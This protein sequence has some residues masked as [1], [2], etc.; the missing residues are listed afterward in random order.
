[1]TRA[2]TRDA[3]VQDILTYNREREDALLCEAAC[4]SSDAVRLNPEREKT[5]D[6]ANV[7]SAY[8]HDADKILHSLAYTRYIDKT[9]VFYLFDN[10]HITHRVLHVQFVSKIAR[11]IARCLQLN[12]DLV[13]AISLGHDIGHV[14][15]GHDGERFLNEICLSS[16]IGGFCHN[17]QSVRWLLELENGGDGI[18]LCLQTIDGILTHNGEMLERRLEPQREKTWETV[19]DEYRQ[20]MM[21]SAFSKTVRPMT[22]EGCVM[23]VADIIGYVGRDLEDAI[24]LGVISRND[25]PRG[26]VAVLGDTNAA[27]INTLA[28]DCI[29]NSVGRDAVG[30]SGSVFD[31]LAELLA[32]NLERIY[33]NAQVREEDEKLRRLFQVVYQSCLKELRA[34]DPQSAVVVFFNKVSSRNRENMAIPPAR[35]VVDFI[36]GMTDSYFLSRAREHLL[37]AGFGVRAVSAD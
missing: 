8:F 37:P 25:L 13:E 23:R 21:R 17:A 6:W 35:I 29:E 32:F 4:R 11:T 9:Q 14:P 5:P 26:A 34:G 3:I 20:C 7:R 27:I 19:I 28:L 10:D 2:K 31:A 18:N 16:G 22:L 33:C 1:M 12:E 36:A 24:T 15:F 30:F